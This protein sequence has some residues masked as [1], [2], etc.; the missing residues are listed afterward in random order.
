MVRQGDNHVL[1]SGSN[2]PE[3]G[4]EIGAWDAEGNCVRVSDGGDG[5]FLSQTHYASVRRSAQEILWNYSNGNGIKN[6][7]TAF[8][9]SILEF[10]RYASQSLPITFEGVDYQQLVL[11]EGSEVPAG[12]TLEAGIITA[13]GTVAEGEWTIEVT[14]AGVDGYINLTAPV[15][16]KVVDPIH[17]S[18]DPA[19]LKVG[20]AVEMII[21]APY[22]SY[23]GYVKVNEVYLNTLS[24]AEGN[25]VP[26]TYVQDGVEITNKGTGD[27]VKG[28]WNILNWYWKDAAHR[29]GKG[30]YDVMG[31]LAFADIQ[32]TDARYI[33][34]ADVEAGNYYKAFPYEWSISEEDAAKLAEYGLT[35]EKVIVSHAGFQGINYDLNASMKLV[36]TPTKAGTV[37]VTVTLQLPLVA[38]LGNRFPNFNR[39]TSPVVTEIVRTITLTIG[40]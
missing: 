12:F 16:I 27:S 17:I 34:T 11:A 29:P 38:G 25:S 24:D 4:L 1:G 7:Y 32:A 36:G 6:G 15:V 3:V 8:E 20:E 30:S 37:D 28:T 5:T 10:D 35:A 23:G 19:A 21:D 22:Y 2:I 26:G 31:H 13:D 33:D 18:G 14:M 9:P 40:E 39:L